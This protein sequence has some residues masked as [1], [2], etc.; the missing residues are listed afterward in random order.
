MKYG[1]SL[2]RFLGQCAVALAAGVGA[3]PRSLGAQHP[4]Q[5]RLLVTPP[6]AQDLATQLVEGFCHLRNLLGSR[7]LAEPAL[8]VLRQ[9]FSCNKTKV[10]NAR[11][12]LQF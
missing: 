11:C 7:H 8:E 2:G 12:Q 10:T 9:D 3:Q 6:H 4:V 5:Q 1:R